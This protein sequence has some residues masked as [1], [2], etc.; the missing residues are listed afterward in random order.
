MCRGRW[1]SSCKPLL[2]QLASR[3]ELMV[4]LR[5]SALPD[6]EPARDQQ[7]A[8]NQLLGCAP[9]L[10]N[11]HHALARRLMEQATAELHA[12]RGSD[13]SPRASAATGAGA[14]GV[15]V[16]RVLQVTLSCPTP[17]LP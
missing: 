11:L 12:L 7:Y 10:H 1:S 5:A 14:V 4:H 17:S 8:A 16:L 2:G 6:A 9:K 3:M 15:M 13:L